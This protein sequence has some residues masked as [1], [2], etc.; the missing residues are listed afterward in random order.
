[1]G[2]ITASNGKLVESTDNGTTAFRHWHERHPI[3][4]YLVSIA[5]FPYSVV[6]DW[7]HSTPTDSMEIRFHLFPE[8]VAPTAAVNAKVKDMIA[9]FTARYVPYPFLDEKYGHAQFLFGGGME[10]QTCTSLGAFGEFVVAHELSHQWWGD[11][12]TCRDFHHI[13]L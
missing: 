10:H 9:A 4:T 12:V 3:S 6:T 7:Y 8:N 13:W 11:G 2:Y 5:S 1:S